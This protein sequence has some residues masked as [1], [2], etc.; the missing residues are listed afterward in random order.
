[1]VQVREG[2][3]L[4]LLLQD[5]ARSTRRLEVYS[6]IHVQEMEVRSHFPLL[7]VTLLL[8]LYLPLLLMQVL[9]VQVREGILLFLLM[10]EQARS[11]RRLEVYCPI[12][13]QEMEERS[14]SPLL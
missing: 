5:Q 12:Q 9:L 3:L 10:R 4:F 14:R 6:P 1:M 7:A 8:A 13:I 2:I 11:T